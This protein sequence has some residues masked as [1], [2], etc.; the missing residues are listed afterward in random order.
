MMVLGF[1]RDSFTGT[2]ASEGSRSLM[3]GKYCCDVCPLGLTCAA[4]GRVPRC[5][6]LVGNCCTIHS[7][8][9]LWW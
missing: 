2:C 5:G 1:Y 9:T 3:G 6:V 4:D 8:C 7:Y